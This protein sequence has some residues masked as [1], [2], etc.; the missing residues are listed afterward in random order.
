MSRVCD[1]AACRRPKAT[2][3]TFFDNIPNYIID[4]VHF[5]KIYAECG[6][7]INNSLIDRLVYH[8]YS[9]PRINTS[10]SHRRWNE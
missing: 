10:L 1:A 7:A 5:P 2:Q 4:R 9:R 6:G 3:L 8:P